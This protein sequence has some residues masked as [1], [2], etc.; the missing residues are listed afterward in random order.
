MENMPDFYAG[1]RKFR[2]D[3][4]TGRVYAV[5]GQEDMIRYEADGT[6]MEGHAFPLAYRDGTG[7]YPL[8]KTA[9]E[10]FDAMAKNPKGSFELSEDLD[11]SAVSADTAAVAGTFTGELDGNGFR[12]RNLPTSLFGTLSGAYIHDLVI[13]DADVTTRRSGILAN[14][15]QNRSRVENVF[16]VD[17]SISNDV[18]GMG[19]FAGRL[20]NSS[21]RES[22]SVNVSVKGLVAAGGIVG[23][24]EDGALIEDCYVTGKVQGSYDHPSLGARTGGIAGWHGG[25]TIRRCYTQAQIIAPAQKGNGGIIG[26]PDKGTPRIEYSLSMSTGAGYRIAGFDVLGNAEE[27]YEYAGSGS[28][29]NITADNQAGVKETDAVYDR[30]FYK[31]TLGFDE[32]IWDLEGLSYGKRPALQDSPVEENY[33]GIPNYSSVAGHAGYR[34]DREKAY[35]N[36]AKMMPLSD[37]RMW[38]ELGNRLS[39]E[40]AFASETVRF[41]LPLDKEG[42]LVS[43]IRRSDPGE[44]EKIRVVFENGNMQEYPV[45][46]RKL[47]G[48]LAAAYQVEGAD[49]RYQFRKFASDIDETLLSETAAAAAGYDYASDIAALTGE[50][51]SRLY[52]DYYNENIKTWMEDVL[53][54]IF[55]SGDGYPTYCSH[56]AVRALAQEKMRDG[57]E[58]KGC[59]TPTTTMIN[60][61]VLTT[62]AST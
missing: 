33:Y 47:T 3:E 38:V 30:N 32:S 37:T 11:A 51:E 19:A 58:I 9:Q 49:L 7:E 34:P 6:R 50:D 12:I 62:A 61:T 18:D 40:D 29:T 36:I 35:A 54:K 59:C 60:G 8:I 57:Q 43:G 48:G 31:D 39:D 55:S 24:T 2:K 1:I 15:I 46:Y 45:T 44:I 14:V 17:S 4:K 22:A 21:I 10:L 42:A 52:T 27:V 56:T 53:Q 20:V 26:G 16:L 23:K 28:I 13:E 25:G 41:V 5:L